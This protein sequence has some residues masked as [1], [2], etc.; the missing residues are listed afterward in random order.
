M[1]RTTIKRDPFARTE[2]VRER[3]LYSDCCSNCGGWSNGGHTYRYGTERDDRPG[4][5]AWH[6]GEFCGKR[7]H[8][9]YHS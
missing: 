5:I 2:L 3:M 6:H 9:I 1:P 7:C 4:R 8:D